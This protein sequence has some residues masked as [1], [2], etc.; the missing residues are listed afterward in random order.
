MPQ[1]K[2]AWKTNLLMFECENNNSQ[3]RYV[4]F[5]NKG[6]CTG[7]LDMNTDCYNK[8]LAV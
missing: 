1:Y 7:L 4:S 8:S 5:P 2:D 3:P 6:A